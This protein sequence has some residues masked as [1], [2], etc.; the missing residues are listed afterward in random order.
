MPQVH[1]QSFGKIRIG[2]SENDFLCQTLLSEAVCKCR[3][4]CAY[5]DL[6]TF[7]DFRFDSILPG[8][9]GFLRPQGFC[10]PE[11]FQITHGIVVATQE[12][13]DRLDSLTEFGR[14]GDGTGGAILDGKRQERLD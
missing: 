1:R 11:I 4:N 7:I 10:R 8:L 6:T 5:Y 9:L 3:T 13:V 14:I 12:Q 2:I